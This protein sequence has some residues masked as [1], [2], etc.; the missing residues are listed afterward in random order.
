MSKTLLNKIG[1]G[2]S[3]IALLA[4]AMISLN[5]CPQPVNPTS[6]N[7]TTPVNPIVTNYDLTITSK[8]LDVINEGSLYSYQVNAT[9]KEG[10]K[11]TYSLPTKPAW[12]SINANSGLIS[13]TVPPISQ[14]TNENV[15]V[16]VSDGKN[17]ATQNFTLT[18][19]N[20][21]D[22]IGNI[23]DNETYTTKAGE[24]KIYDYDDVATY[25][26]DYLGNKYFNGYNFTSKTPLIDQDVSSGNFSQIQLPKVVSKAVLRAK[27][28]PDSYIRTITLD[29][30]KDYTSQNNNSLT[31]KIRVV[32]YGYWNGTSFDLTNFDAKSFKEFMKEIN[33]D[34]P[35]LSDHGLKKWN[36]DNLLGIE[37]LKSNPNDPS[38]TFTDSQQQAIVD[39][40]KNSL[41]IPLFIN[42]KKDLGLII[43]QDLTKSDQYSNNHYDSSGDPKRGYIIVVPNSTLMGLVDNTETAIAGKT[44]YYPAD[45][46]T[47]GIIK[48]NK[49][50][51]RP[52]DAT[53]NNRT[54]S[55][56]FGHA[57]I[58]PNGEATI[59]SDYTI[60]YPYNGRIVKPADADIKAGKIIYED[61]YLP[62]EKLDDILG[63]NWMN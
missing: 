16:S 61:T 18:E 52:G 20:L 38:S 54:V 43:Q 47:D 19:K 35:S 49:I 12:L 9:D 50:E 33:F 8:A 2:A 44:S 62:R 63:L 51:I 45:Y 46:L 13:G 6:V 55:H 57:F 15:G 3:R 1:K 37:I 60:M 26:T 21:L 40:I 10:D 36:L 7:P 48:R 14:D 24:V 41:D 5:G 31:D 25:G 17:T 29:G 59:L 28:N 4:T 53:D 34:D 56:E 27:L 39:K 22:I 42:N 11:L 30:T 58:A 32:P 23:Q